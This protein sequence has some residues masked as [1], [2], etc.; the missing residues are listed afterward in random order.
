MKVMVVVVVAIL[1][2]CFVASPVMH[3]GGGK[4]SEQVQHEGIDKLMPSQLTA[5]DK[6]TGEI[7]VARLRVW[8][9]DQYRGQ[10]VRWQHGF[11]DQLDYANQVLG[12]ML[13]IRLEAEYRTWDHH[14]PGAPLSD[15]LEALA[16]E[17]PG[18]GVV[19]VVGLTS[20][21]SLVA[22]TFEQIGVA[23]LGGRHLVVRG[24]A[25]LEERKAFERAFPDIDREQREQ[26]LEARRRHK[27]TAL[28]I[29]ELAHSLGALHETEPDWI[30][31]PTYSHRA[32]SISARNRELMLIRLEDRLQP[33]ADHDPRGT[34][35]KLLAALDVEW[36]G[37][38]AG[39][40]D[41]LI[42]SLREQG[43]APAPVGITGELPAI[44]IARARQAAGD[45]AGAYATLAAAEARLDSLPRERAAPAW[46]ALADRYREIDAV[47]RAERALA[48][49]G[50]GA[51]DPGIAAWAQ[52]TRVR[53]GIPR[54]GARY[55]L[56]PD[57]EPDALAAVHD[58]LAK[59]YANQLDAAARAAG[60][61]EKRWPGLP[62]VVAARCDLELRR[63]AVGTARSLCAHA[64]AHGESSWA[65]Y[66]SGVI[67]LQG[68]SQAATT[69]GVA[70]LRQAIEIDPDLAQAWRALGKALVRAGHTAERERLAREYYTR[71]GAAL[72]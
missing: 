33:P 40:R 49:A 41:Q 34:A 27:T 61:A 59:V 50:A 52:V 19:W 30:M 22:G 45:A 32:A 20:S 37:W 17:D 67:E 11:D 6:W 56:A 55:Q 60:A 58:V 24:H 53:Y 21:L 1:S 54:D 31:N 9:D 43:G 70:R 2:G 10:N 51:A 23:S 64:I 28:L 15:H 14:A 42:A 71:F 47:T 69:T 26:V 65:M 57:D 12:P 68:G 62:G 63:G 35:R 25:D 16:R 8:A 46:L 4:T 5:L 29:H 3:F 36:G 72:P 18:E 38:V 39:D 13:G 48:K 7:R 66:L 44:E